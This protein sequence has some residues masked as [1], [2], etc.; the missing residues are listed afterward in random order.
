[1]VPEVNY[2]GHKLSAEGIHTSDEKVVA[3]DSF[4]MPTNKNEL[5]VFCGMVKYYH[6][7]LP[8]VSEI[9]AP[10]FSLV[11]HNSVWKWGDCESKAFLSAKE[12]LKSNNLLAHYDANKPLF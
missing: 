3:I 10:L 8:R 4:P 5:S 11:S 6:R 12:L 7:F 2:L 1:M 9:M